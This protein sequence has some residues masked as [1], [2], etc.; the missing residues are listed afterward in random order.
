[1]VLAHDFSPNFQSV[2]ACVG[3]QVLVPLCVRNDGFAIFKLVAVVFGPR[4]DGAV[5]AVRYDPPT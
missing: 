5:K 2:S 4:E 1:M 3:G